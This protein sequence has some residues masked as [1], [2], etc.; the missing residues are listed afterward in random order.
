MKKRLNVI[1]AMVLGIFLLAG[2]NTPGDSPQEAQTNLKIGLLR[3]DDSLPF[4]IAEQEGL[5]EKYGVDVELIGFSSGKDQSIALE[6][7]EL[8]GLMT[9]MVVQG[10]LKKSGTEI[11]TVAMALGAVPEEGRFLVVAAPESGIDSAADLAGKRV[12]IS[13]NTMMDYLMESFAQP[14]GFDYNSL[15]LVNM[16]DLMLRV[17]TLLEGKDIDAAILPDPLAA[18]AV[19]EGAQVVIDDTRL[20][21]NLSQSV[22]AVT[23]LAL[24]EKREAVGKMLKAY[25]EAIELINTHPEDYRALCLKTASVPE[26]LAET[27]PIPSYT[28]HSVPDEE[29]VQNVMDWLVQ[30]GLIEQAY[31]YEEIVDGA[32]VHE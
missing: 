4:Y 6:S 10:L 1:A 32:F 18:Y 15:E 11:K 2:C 28:A 29:S 12:A 16:P 20:G 25:N 26:K 23:D 7:G 24:E 22:V 3:I 27:Y 30:R 21:E 19:A 9:D 5:F 14:A 8:D 13:K 17:T 31:T